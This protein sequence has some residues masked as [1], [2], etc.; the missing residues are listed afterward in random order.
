M[1][2]KPLLHIGSKKNFKIIETL[3]LIIENKFV[4][5]LKQFNLYAM[6][7]MEKKY[8]LELLGV[9]VL[10]AFQKVQR[11]ENAKKFIN[12]LNKTFNET[13]TTNLIKLLS[14]YEKFLKLND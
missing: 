8:Q 12:E 5:S 9:N 11:A 2:L 13:Q 7:T 1:R 10:E 14:K 4:D 3:L 6:K